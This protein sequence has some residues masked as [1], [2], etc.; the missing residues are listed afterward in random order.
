KMFEMPQY[1]EIFKMQTTGTGTSVTETNVDFHYNGGEDAATTPSVVAY[2]EGWILLASE[3]KKNNN[4]YDE[5]TFG[6]NKMLTP[7][8]TTSKT[9]FDKVQLKS[10][11]DQEV[12]GETNTTTKIDIQA[13]GIQTRNLNIAGL[14]DDAQTPS[15]TDLGNIFNII[16]NKKNIT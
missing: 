10:F 4:D 1:V 8:E 3:T 5:Y 15:S 6:Y 13:Y 12:T 9:L 2:S 7:N 14:A 16:K 11:I